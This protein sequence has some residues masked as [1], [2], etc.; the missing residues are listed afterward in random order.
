MAAFKKDG[1]HISL[2]Q[3][4]F[5]PPREDNPLFVEGQQQGF[6]GMSKMADGSRGNELFSY[7]EGSDGWKIDDA[8]IDFS[9][10]D[11]SHWYASK[12]SS[13]IRQGAS[14][15]KTD[16][17]DCIPPDAYYANIEGRRFQNLFSLVYNA[18]I[19]SAIRSI[20]P[21]TVVWARSGTAGSQRYPIHWGGD[22]QCSWSALQGTL[23]A[24][25][26]IGLSGFA[27][28]SHDIGGFIGKPSPELYVRWAQLGLLG[29]SHSRS[30]GAGNDNS[31]EPW[32]F[33][34]EALS[35]F[36]KVADLRYQLLPYIVQ[37]AR[38]GV[39]AGLPLI[40][41]LILDW[42]KD[43]NVW[44]IE[45][46]YMMGDS[47]LVMPVLMPQEELG[48]KMEMYLPVGTWYI[49]QSNEKVESRGEWITTQTPGL[50]SMAIWVLEGSMICYAE[51]GRQRTWNSP[52]SVVRAELYGQQRRYA[53]KP[54]VWR[55]FDGDGRDI[56][57][58]QGKDSQWVCSGDSKVIVHRF[59]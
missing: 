39:E 21:D 53:E 59:V 18:T 20:D 16:F 17:G 26:S 58:E 33:G 1:I 42:P 3:Y 35:A 12:I 25:L 19:W 10:S 2:W 38:S 36:R 55:C 49:F 44:Q 43:R 13:L 56:V 41:H 40:R 46:Q 9:N 29:A 51:E 27:Y 32:A 7:P 37:Q 50:N 31:R 4:N 23:K 14:A 8:V 30:H 47:L 48:D 11:A 57:V 45:N 15:I 54:G 24:T 28:F 22:S 5:A 52:G 34:D 6:F